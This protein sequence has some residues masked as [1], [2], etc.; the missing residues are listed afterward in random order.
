M[1]VKLLLLKIVFC[2]P[3]VLLGQY[4]SVNKVES[5]DGLFY[6]VQIGTL[7]TENV[8]EEYQ[9]IS[10]INIE[11]L[12]SGKF[13]FSSGV[14]RE[15]KYA[16]SRRDEI[17][18]AGLKGAFIIAYENGKRISLREIRNRELSPVE[19]VASTTTTKKEVPQSTPVA[20]VSPKTEAY[21]FAHNEAYREVSDLIENEIIDYSDNKINS[22]TSLVR[23]LF[24]REL[25]SIPAHTFDSIYKAE[26][27]R[28]LKGDVGLNLNSWYLHNFE[29]G[30]FEN[31]DLAYFDRLNITMNWDLLRGGLL[32]NRLKAKR[33]Q[34]ALSQD[35]IK[36][37]E[38][39]TINKYENIYNYIIYLFNKEKLK[40]VEKRISLLNRQVQIHEMLYTSKEKS[41]EDII[42]LKSRI[43]RTENMYKKWSYYNKIIEQI[44]FPDQEISEEID[45]RYL[46]ILDIVPDS[47]FNSGLEENENYNRLVELEKENINLQHNRW[48][49]WNL[50]PFVRYNLIGQ[51]VPF[52][53]HY[54]SLGLNV[55]MPIR[56]K[57]RKQLKE[58]KKL[59]LE[60]IHF[61]KELNDDHEL[62]NYFYE[63]QYKL[64]QT[65]EFHYKIFK[66]EEKLRKEIIKFQF[67]DINFLPLHAIG[68]M[69]ELIS[70]KLELLDLRQQLY[71]KLLKI[72]EYIES[73]SPLEYTKVVNPDNLLF[74]YAQK[75]TV[76]LWSKFF[77]QQDNLFLIH[78]LKVNEVKR[79]LFSIGPSPDMEKLKEFSQLAE[80]YGIELHGM[81]GNNNLANE[82]D[83]ELLDSRIAQ[84]NELG[85]SGV[86]FDIEPQTFPDWEA[87]QDK[88]VDNIINVINYVKEID[89]EKNFIVS[90]SISMYYSENSLQKVYESCDFVNIMAYETPDIQFIKEKTTEELASFREKTIISLRTKDFKNRLYLEKFIEELSEELDLNQI[91]IHDLGTLFDL[92][93]TSSIERQ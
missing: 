8:P 86:H 30:F 14:F 45:A 17:I 10:D 89:Q 2:F 87:N 24:N 78:Y 90:A 21:N 77:Q 80:K 12:E 32:E 48:K 88:Y 42:V 22:D 49:D 11:K 47:L 28:Q 20:P 63:Y 85:F 79:V 38:I 31:E 43:S 58:A 55:T 72:S 52:D 59:K 69:D 92:D 9:K 56:F 16:R 54:A 91:T 93:N 70:V 19:T 29:P 74:K 76:Y 40:A 18:N 1:N 66:I 37:Q 71:L 25:D 84:Y 39:K 7:S 5:V 65:I 50:R 35:Q 75:R 51:R 73:D 13:R 15:L 64:E 68:Y 62:L 3:I 33:L 67:N 60:N 44:I 6:T 53:R 57:G 83:K 26:Q 41:W 61:K 82:L 4:Y 36:Q 46:P 34:N 27:I 81:I 23:V